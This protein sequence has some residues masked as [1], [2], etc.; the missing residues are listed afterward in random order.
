MGYTLSIDPGT[1]PETLREG[2]SK[3]LL[4][5]AMAESVAALMRS[6]FL[7]RNAAAQPKEG[8]P[9]TGYWLKA[10]SSVAW[11]REESGATVSASG[12]G[13]ALRL[14]GGVVT[15]R[16]GRA[17]AI[18]VDPRV[19]TVWPSEAAQ[20]AKTGKKNQPNAVF[21]WWPKGRRAGILA[22][23]EKNGHLH[24]LWVLVAKSVQK[25]DP[26]V[27]PSPAD[28]GAAAEEGAQIVVDSLRRRFAT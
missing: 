17:L 18:P 10:R 2:L 8:F 15:P 7:A 3:D 9:K 26:G 16:S 20:R 21:L 5:G 24:A 12:P 4:A 22:E 28:I 13:L 19:A 25:P 11:H 14:H 1:V 27:L 23:R 6:H